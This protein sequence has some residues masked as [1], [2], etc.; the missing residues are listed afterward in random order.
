MMARLTGN[1][2]GCRP[3]VGALLILALGLAAAPAWAQQTSSGTQSTEDDWGGDDWGDD[4]WA[5][6]QTGWQWYGFVEGAV[7]ARLHN[8]PAV[9]EDY[10][11]AETRLQ[12]EG[13]RGVGDYTATIKGDVWLDGVEDSG[14]GDLREANLQGRL[15]DAIDIE[16]GRQILTWG[17]GDLVFLNDLFPKDYVSFFSGRNDEYLK[18]P[19]DAIKLSFYGDAN[20]DVVYMPQGEANRFITGERLSYFSPRRGAVTAAPPAI[21]PDERDDWLDDSELALRLYQ[22]VDGVEYAGYAFHGYDKQPSA[23]DPAT[24]TPY[25]PR[26]SVLGASIRRPAAGGIANA[27]T[28]YYFA[29]DSS[30]DDPDRPNEQWRFLLGYEHEPLADLTLGWQYYLEWT[31]DHDA[32]ID[33][34]PADQRRYAPD[35]YRHLLTNRVTW[36]LLRQDLT[37]SLFSFFSPSDADY[38]FRPR[39]EY[40]FSDRLTGTVGGN[41]FGGEDPWTFHTQLQDNSNAYARIRYNF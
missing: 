11:L 14:R 30:G 31:Q 20:L 38:F 18:A 3:L 19:S 41:V 13:E 15:T 10:T 36:Q 29:D 1:P 6:E 2:R 39:A 25:F 32:L 9:D 28:A 17:T 5:S 8:D 35:E 27:E 26:L 40:R 7:A 21:D 22:T 33:A 4:P 16:A 23:A 37:I 34:T 24:G 12:I